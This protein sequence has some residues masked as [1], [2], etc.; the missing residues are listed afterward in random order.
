VRSIPRIDNSFDSDN[1]HFVIGIQEEWPPAEI[2]LLATHKT[3]LALTERLD[4]KAEKRKRLIGDMQGQARF[5][6]ARRHCCVESTQ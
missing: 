3:G 4:G 1:R 5:F 6:G 2:H